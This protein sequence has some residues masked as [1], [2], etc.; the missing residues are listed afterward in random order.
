MTGVKS[1]L[2]EELEKNSPTLGR[3]A[4]YEKT[5]S[6]LKIKNKKRFVILLAFLCFF[7]VQTLYK[8]N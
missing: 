5:V 2:K 1:K 6:F 8:Y 7:Y 3:N 4:K